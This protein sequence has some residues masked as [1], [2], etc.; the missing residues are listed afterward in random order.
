MT[1]DSGPVLPDLVGRQELLIGC[2]AV[3]IVVLA[4]LALAAA[5]PVACTA[6]AAC[7]TWGAVATARHGHGGAS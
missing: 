1:P 3:L 5:T 6:W 2:V 7:K 4:P